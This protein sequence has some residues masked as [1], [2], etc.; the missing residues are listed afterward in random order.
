[1]FENESAK[2]TELDLYTNGTGGY[3]LSAKYMV[4]DKHSVRE[5]HIP[6]IQLPI[7]PSRVII[8]TNIG[9]G[10]M[11]EHHIDMGFGRLPLQETYRGGRHVLY[12]EKI[13]EEKC[14]E[15]TLDEIE[16]A[17]GYKVKIVN[18]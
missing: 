4:E 9:D 17:L 14:T 6:R 10:A 5:L 11:L 3:F 13:L 1:M 15:M 8:D 12:T 7:S 18:K 16:N 2:L